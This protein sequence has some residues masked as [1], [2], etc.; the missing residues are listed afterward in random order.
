MVDLSYLDNRNNPD[1]K[2]PIHAR[3]GWK[4]PQERLDQFHI[5]KLNYDLI[6]I[7]SEE[8]NTWHPNAKIRSLSDYP[9]NCMG[10]VFASRRAVISI[11][12]VYRILKEDGFRQISRNQCV[13]GD[14]VL[15]KNDNEPTHIGIIT[16]I[17]K[18]PTSFTVLSRWGFD[19]EFEH[20]MDD[21]PQLYGNA[22][23]FYTERKL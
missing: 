6:K 20:F 12:H 19:A 16:Y 13:V 5:E 18:S 17:T 22:T 14:I 10:L 21:V 8:L 2:Y 9:Y 1:D 23:E 11:E 7:R 3:S 4:I 15:Y